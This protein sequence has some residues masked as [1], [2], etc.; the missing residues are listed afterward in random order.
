MENISLKLITFNTLGIPFLTTH[1]YRNYLGISRNLLAR[2]RYI[3]DT[4]NTSGADILL[5]QEVHLYSLLRLLKKKLTNYPYVY[6]HPFLYG[7]KSGLVIFSKQE[8]VMEP[9]LNFTSRGSVKNKTIVTKIIRNGALICRLKSFPLYILNTY[10]T[11]N[12]SH[13]WDSESKYTTIQRVQL[14]ELQQKVSQL[15]STHADVI[16]AGD[17]NITP[18]SWLYQSFIKELQLTDFF[19]NSS[20]Y[21]HHPEFLPSWATPPR[22]DH[23]FCTAINHRVENIQTEELFTK[24]VLLPNKKESYL[25]DHV[26]LSVSFT[27]TK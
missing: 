12:F 15:Q 4:L 1:K 10:I 14:N 5:L 2:F 8:L 11:G 6:Y 16:I 9:F 13:R 24:K 25:S 3:G 18:S 26:A 22:L 27:L 21:T 7:P 23:I 19:A 20:T 17:M